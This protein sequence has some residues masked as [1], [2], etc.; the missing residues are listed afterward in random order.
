MQELKIKIKGLHSH[1]S[2][3]SAVP[4]GALSVADDIVIDKEEIAEPRRGFD[5]SN[6]AFS[7]GT[8]RANKLAFYKNYLLAQYSTNLLAYYST[9]L[10]STSADFTG[11]GSWTAISGTYAP[12]S[13]ERMRF[14]EANSNL[15][16]T[17]SAGVYKMAEIAASA[18][19]KAGAYKGLDL[20][21]SSNG[22][23]SSW[24]ANNEY[25]AYRLV[26]GYKDANNNLIHTWWV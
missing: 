7:D 23:T 21:A 14:A 1:A 15:Y 13:G 10:S 8:Y 24:L 5:Q 3:L 22:A 17:T 19:T 26:W 18:L 2:D 6:A 20:N 11:S 4:E 12:P 16:L 9:E 25:T